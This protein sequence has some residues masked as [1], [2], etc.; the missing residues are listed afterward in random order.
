MPYIKD[1][2]HSLLRQPNGIGKDSFFQKDLEDHPA[3]VKTEAIYSEHVKKDINYLVCKDLDHL[4]LMVQLGC[5]EINPWNSRVGRLNKPDWVVVDLDPESIGFNKVIEAALVVKKVCNELDIPTY[6]KTSG[7][8]GIHIYIPTAGK[9]SYD[10]GKEL[11]Q[12]LANLVHDRIPQ[13]T[14]VERLPKK[15]QK[16]VYLDFLQNRKGQTLA[17]PYS[18]RP[19]PQAT[20]SSPLHWDEVKKGLNPQKFTIK[21]IQQRLDKVGDLWKPVLGPGVNIPRILKLLD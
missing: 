1:R 5:I 12:R 4:L 11:A 7:K 18:V 8:T 16:K 21:N 14:S 3:W 19:T 15:R 9:Y 2:P 13:F 6:P 20:V 17:A 10:Q